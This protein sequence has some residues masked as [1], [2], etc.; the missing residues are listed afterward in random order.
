[1]AQAVPSKL[2]LKYAVAPYPQDMYILSTQSGRFG[3]C[4]CGSEAAACT[5]LR[6]Q[7]YSALVVNMA[8]K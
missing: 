4:S 7:P 2:S 1:M 6:S 8:N 3:V 5:G